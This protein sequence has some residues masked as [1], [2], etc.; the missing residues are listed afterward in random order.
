MPAL[1]GGCR[2]RLQPAPISERLA[3]GGRALRIGG[4]WHTR[5]PLRVWT[6]RLTAANTAW[7]WRGNRSEIRRAL[8]KLEEIIQRTRT[9]EAFVLVRGARSLLLFQRER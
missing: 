2:L 7:C 3:L 5:L 9:D 4:R 1:L 8:I 6:V